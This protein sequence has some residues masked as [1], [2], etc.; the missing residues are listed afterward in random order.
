LGSGS[1]GKGSGVG[2]SRAATE[3]RENAGRHRVSSAFLQDLSSPGERHNGQLPRDP[4]ILHT[5][6]PAL[7]ASVR[8][9]EKWI[10]R[11]GRDSWDEIKVK[12]LLTSFKFSKGGY[13]LKNFIFLR[14]KYLK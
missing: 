11:E 8:V 10:L 12:L 5:G 4:R 7:D 3:I 13:R 6:A 14:H 1:G 2:G 9:G